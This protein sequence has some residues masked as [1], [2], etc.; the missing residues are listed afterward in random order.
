MF[1]IDWLILAISESRNSYYYLV[2]VCVCTIFAMP[3]I[4]FWQKRIMTSSL[5]SVGLIIACW[6]PKVPKVEF[7]L[8]SRNPE[9]KEVGGEGTLAVCIE[10]FPIR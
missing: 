7:G 1:P 5:N 10:Q 6:A 3:C 9:N 2:S 4:L 8:E